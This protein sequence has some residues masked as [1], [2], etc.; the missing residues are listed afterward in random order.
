[1]KRT[2]K[3]RLSDAPV[4]DHVRTLTERDG[5]DEPAVRYLRR[6]QNGKP[7][8]YQQ[9]AEDVLHLEFGGLDVRVQ[10][11]EDHIE[12]ILTDVSARA[13]GVARAA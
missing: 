3:I 9:D 11:H 5:W 4:P 10:A 13:S 2:M 6:A 7:R 8:L 12:V 1:M